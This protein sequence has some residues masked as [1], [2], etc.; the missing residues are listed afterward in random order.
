MFLPEK[1]PPMAV[2]KGSE[3]IDDSQ[4]GTLELDLG[5]TKSTTNGNPISY[6]TAGRGGPAEKTEGALLRPPSPSGIPSATESRLEGSIFDAAR[7]ANQPWDEA[8]L[9][10]RM[11]R[12][13]NR[14]E[15]AS[16]PV[17]MGVKKPGV[18]EASSR[19]VNSHVTYKQ[20]YALFN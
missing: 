11:Q 3:R 20:S 6:W 16:A 1:T 4:A 9:H 15:A 17:S 10:Q 14:G 12:R 5:S 13:S 8:T 18:R 7:D 19:R 2:Q